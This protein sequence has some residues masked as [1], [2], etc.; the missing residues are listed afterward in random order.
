M[1]KRL[2]YLA[3]HNDV[4]IPKPL[5]KYI[6][7]YELLVSLRKNGIIGSSLFKDISI[8]RLQAFYDSGRQE[9]LDSAN[10]GL[11]FVKIVT[12]VVY[13]NIHKDTSLEL[14]ERLRL[15]GVLSRYSEGKSSLLSS[16]VTSF[17]YADTDRVELIPT[18]FNPLD[19]LLQGVMTSSLI[20]VAASSGHGKTSLMLAMVDSIQRYYPEK[21]IVYFSLEMTSNS[22]KYRSRYLTLKHDKRN[23]IVTGITQLNDIEEYLDLDTIVVL[24]YLDL[25][26]QSS[27]DSLRFAIIDNYAKLLSY[28]KKCFLLFNATQVNRDATPSLRSLSESAAKSH[29]SE[30]VLLLTKNGR[31]NNNPGYNAVEMKCLKNRFGKSDCTVHFDFNYATLDYTETYSSTVDS[32]SDAIAALYDT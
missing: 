29:Y 7:H 32:D 19:E 22:V 3:V 10:E 31:S 23:T 1:Q 21:R 6:P 16:E 2:I 9:M 12:R 24:D 26:L 8:E 28:S 20:T 4:N 17:E 18:G 11:D 13:E 14:D 30:V 25:L 5:Q 27:N 15:L